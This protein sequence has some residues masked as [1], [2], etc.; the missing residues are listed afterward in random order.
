MDMK[1]ICKNQ[2]EEAKA[3][4][5]T[6]SEEVGYD[7]GDEA[8]LEWVEKY[9]AEYRKK[10][11]AVYSEIITKVA[12]DGELI[13]I[14]VGKKLDGETHQELVRVICDKFTE[15]WTKEM[16]INGKSNQ[17]LDEI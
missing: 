4:R 14:I 11:N 8:I 9:A 12:A 2:V 7:L 3:Y 13:D 17:H 16:T 6:R 5:R 1:R 15:V 10:F